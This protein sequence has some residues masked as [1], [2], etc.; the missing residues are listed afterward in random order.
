MSAG[1]LAGAQAKKGM[2]VPGYAGMQPANS[3]VQYRVQICKGIE[4]ISRNGLATVNAGS[5]CNRPLAIHSP[6]SYA[7][8]PE[9]TAAKQS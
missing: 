7:E 2:L 6:Q 8:G 5:G 1:K 3:T 4:H 9:S